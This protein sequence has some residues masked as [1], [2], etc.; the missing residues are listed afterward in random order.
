[1][2]RMGSPALRRAVQRYGTA[3]ALVVIVLAFSAIRPGSFCT[4]K[5]FINITRQISL[6]VVISLG[7]TMVMSVGEFDLSV[8]EMASLGGVMAAQLAVAGAPMA[9]CFTLP[10]LAGAAVGVV[11]GLA[12]ARFRG[13]SFITSLGVSTILS[14]VVYRLSGGA[15]V[16][17][18]IPKSFS[19]LG[20]A[21]L[22]QLPLLS[23]LMAV[24]VLAFWFLMRHTA[25]GRR[26]YAIGGGEEAARVAGIRVKRYKVLAFVLC[27]VMACVTGMLIASR[28]GS[29][30][31]TAGDGYFL[32]AYA[33]VFI[34]CTASRRGVPN[35]R[36][37]LLG[38]AILGVL[39]NGLTM[40]QT[41]SYLQDILTGGIIIL[42]V[43]AQRLGKEDAQ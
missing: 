16:F 26:L 3:A 25:A 6:L 40:L 32:K 30:N 13:L 5:N 4:L 41:P 29:A 19:V 9:V 12:A 1:M 8:G 21:R 31:T 28:V 11:N 23:V 38:A 39:A 24:F 18:N 17:E 27:A 15:T 10:V 36:G 33:A 2:K 34:G 7:A 42:A 20:T 37:T 35:V 43:A 14:G 22:G